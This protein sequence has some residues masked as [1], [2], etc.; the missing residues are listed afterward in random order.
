[1]DFVRVRTEQAWRAF[2]K[3]YARMLNVLPEED[4]ECR[5]VVKLTPK[6]QITVRLSCDGYCLVAR[7]GV[8]QAVMECNL[9]SALIFMGW[10]EYP[11]YSLALM[12]DS[13]LVLSG[14]RRLKNISGSA[15]F[16]ELIIGLSECA[17]LLITSFE[18]GLYFPHTL[19]RPQSPERL[20]C[21]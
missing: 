17:S 14:V 2:L 19:Y 3:K 6:R 9:Q 18:R 21:R 20:T 1:M 16:H 8:I 13:R 10:Q 15:D 5:I 7:A 12:P 4:D 11:K